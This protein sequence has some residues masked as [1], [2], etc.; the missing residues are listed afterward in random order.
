MC[1]EK[2]LFVLTI[3]R[4]GNGHFTVEN[5]DRDADIFSLILNSERDVGIFS[6]LLIGVICSSIPGLQ[7]SA[8]I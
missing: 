1:R 7:E 6:L 5:S 2:D 3:L 8:K 4:P